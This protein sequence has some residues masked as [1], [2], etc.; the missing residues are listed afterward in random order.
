M[1]NVMS[2]ALVPTQRRA[3]CSTPREQTSIKTDKQLPVN[4]SSPLPIRCRPWLKRKLNMR[5]AET[6]SACK[7]KSGWQQLGWCS[8]APF[9]VA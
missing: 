7:L 1:F 8:V 2:E 4:A 5:K 6:S 9:S 3:L